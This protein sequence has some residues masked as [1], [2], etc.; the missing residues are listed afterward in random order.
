MATILKTA[1]G[2]QAQVARRIDG[3]AVRKAKTFKTKRDAQ[4]WAREFEVGISAGTASSDTLRQVF[5]RYALERSKGKKGERW[6]VIRLNRFAVDLVN[7]KPLGEYVIGDVTTADLVA[8]R[9]MRLGLVKP[10]SV[11]REMNLLKHVF[12]TATKEWGLL[13]INPMEDVR[14]P[15]RA[16]RRKRRIYQDEIDKMFE[17][18]DLACEPWVTEKQITGAMFL[19]AIETAMRSGEIRDIT[20]RHVSG[21][22]IHLPETK[23]DHARDVPLTTRALEI[24]EAVRGNKTEPDQHPFDI[25]AES[26]DSVFRA[27]AK[28]AKIENLHFHD[29]RHEA[30]TRLAKRFEILDLARVTGHKNLNELLTYYE[31][32]GEELA[33]RLNSSTSKDETK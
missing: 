30:I 4:V 11:S 22:V 16:K 28:R 3:K 15:A 10:A 24:L 29:T 33:E 17:A 13:R 23:N 5:D 31:A 21:N 19:F 14:R 8:W 1:H 12:A 18:L 26:R 9:D 27:A 7:G 25:D 6:E 20:N 32:S 2:W